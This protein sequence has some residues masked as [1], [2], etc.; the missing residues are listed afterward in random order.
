MKKNITY[1]CLLLAIF[2]A[3]SQTAGSLDTSF[4]TGGKVLTGFTAVTNSNDESY[5]SAIQT[6]GKIVTVGDS[7]IASGNYDF[8]IVRYLTN[9]TLDTTFGTQ[10]KVTFGLGNYD[11]ARAVAINTDGKIYVVGGTGG[12]SLSLSTNIT[13]IR[14]NTNGTLDTTFGTAGVSTFGLTGYDIPT[15]IT[16]QSDGKILISGNNIVDLT[17][18]YSDLSLFRI[19]PDGTLDLD[20]SNDGKLTLNLGDEDR[21]S[22]IEIDAS[23]KIL[24]GGK[25]GSY[26]G[27]ARYNQDGSFDNTFGT[28][29]K[30]TLQINERS[31][32]VGD[33]KIQTDGKIVLTGSYYSSVAS[34]PD[35][36]IARLNSN[37]TFD[38]TFGTNGY[39][40][41]DVDNS[42]SD[43][44]HALV[45]QSNGRIIVS[46][47]TSTGGTN[48]FLSMRYTTDGALDTSFSFDGIILTSFGSNALELHNSLLQP[49]GKLLVT[50]HYGYTF[51]ADFALA[52]YHTEDVLGVTDFSKSKLFIFPNPANDVLY[53]S[54][55]SILNGV[56]YTIFDMQ[57]RSILN[58]N[59]SSMNDK[60]DISHLS[61]G[62]Y[63]FSV[64]QVT[65]AIK[66]IKN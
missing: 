10:G 1:L 51:G 56:N 33:F 59:L 52:R 20:F 11:S 61:K 16:I 9:G 17:D 50:G 36:Y 54:A 46:G 14:L 18:N 37:G 28:M 42:S 53:I 39:T 25:C 62:A 13:L 15:D 34:N 24:L 38:T 3:Q 27:M 60:I 8:T 66:F 29:G 47:D 12:T 49:D 63:S 31:V 64:L 35:V 4:G 48:Y 2:V 55:D 65:K 5:Y 58:G 41:T 22:I 40:I 7:P 6:D 21:P 19:N 44:G 30:I 32:T 45:L 26:I 23:N 43:S 57:G